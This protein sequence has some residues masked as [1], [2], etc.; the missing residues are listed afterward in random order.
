MHFD[1]FYLEVS[2][3]LDQK[4]EIN[5][6]NTG[7]SKKDSSEKNVHIQFTIGTA[8]VRAKKQRRILSK[9]ECSQLLTFVI[10]QTVKVKT[11]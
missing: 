7:N 9:V 6:I 5:I 4:I 8:E 2:A 3:S 1:T 10:V 11:N